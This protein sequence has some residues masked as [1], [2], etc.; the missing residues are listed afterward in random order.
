M[1]E[2]LTLEKFEEASERVKEVTLE[3]RLVYSEYFSNQTGNKVYFKP[4]N[5]QKM[6][7]FNDKLCRKALDRGITAGGIIL[8]NADGK[9]RLHFFTPGMEF[10]E[11]WIYTGSSDAGKTAGFTVYTP[12]EIT[13]GTV[14][15]LENGTVFFVPFDNNNTRTM[16]DEF[17]QQAAKENIAPVIWPASWPLNR[18]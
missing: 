7:K 6:Y 14:K 17:I 9:T 13:S 8:K 12:K 1:T 18:R 15:N 10:S 16:A 5:M 3:T 4:E 11:L 2:K